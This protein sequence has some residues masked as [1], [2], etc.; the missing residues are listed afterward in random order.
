MGK[1]GLCLCVLPIESLSEKVGMC[2]LLRICVRTSIIRHI[3]MMST[4]IQ[5]RTTIAFPSFRAILLFSVGRLNRRSTNKYV[6]KHVYLPV[7]KQKQMRRWQDK[8][9]WAYLVRMHDAIYFFHAQLNTLSVPSQ[10]GGHI[11]N[12]VYVQLL[13]AWQVVQ[14]WNISISR[15]IGLTTFVKVWRISNWS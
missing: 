5:N 7:L 4:V 6:S 8:R 3:A 9:I 13:Q 1:F 12:A 11:S 14:V 10:G 15:F 2:F